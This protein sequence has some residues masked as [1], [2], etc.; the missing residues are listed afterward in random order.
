MDNTILEMQHIT[1]EFPGVRALDDVC[2]S[3]TAREI[4]CLVGENGA[5]KSTLMK[6]LSGVYPY[7]EYEGEIIFNG[8]VQKY[9]NISDSK[10]AGIAIIIKS[11]RWC[12]N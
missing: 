2:F 8:T 1:K 10:K 12:R 3:V 9:A 11:W 7:G 6:I 5:G 4:H